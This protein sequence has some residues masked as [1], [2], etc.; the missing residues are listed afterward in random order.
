[1]FAVP[2]QAPPTCNILVNHIAPFLLPGHKIGTVSNTSNLRD[3]YKEENRAQLS[4][5]SNFTL[6]PK[7]VNPQY[8]CTWHCMYWCP[9]SYIKFSYILLSEWVGYIHWSSLLSSSVAI[10]IDPY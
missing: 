3:P 8:I 6:G 10:A 1:M 2:L 4:H 7:V 9:D 5:L